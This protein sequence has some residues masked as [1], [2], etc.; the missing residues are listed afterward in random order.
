MKYGV[1]LEVLTAE[2]PDRA[3]MQTSARKQKGGEVELGEE[4]VGEEKRKA[5]KGRREV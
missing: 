2:G 3:A 1:K 4:G 5:G